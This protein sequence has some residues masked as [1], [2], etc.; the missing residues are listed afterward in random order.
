[1]FVDPYIIVQFLKKNPTRW[2]SVSKFFYSFEM[3]LNMFQADTAHHQD[4]KTALAAS[5]FV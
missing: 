4:R 3:K 1:M 2:N 5:G